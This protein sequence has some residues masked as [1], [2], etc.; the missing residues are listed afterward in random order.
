M[1]NDGPFHR[2][3]AVASVVALSMCAHPNEKKDEAPLA[4][5]VDAGAVDTPLADA[6]D[7]ALD[8]GAADAGAVEDAGALAAAPLDGG[9]ADA[10]AADAG[11]LD[12]GRA[13]AGLAAPGKKAPKKGK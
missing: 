8:A 12:A 13:D 3:L 5:T 6:G 11:A 9:T 7:V 10:G 1:P 4:V 2:L